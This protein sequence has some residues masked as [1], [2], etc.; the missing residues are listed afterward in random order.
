MPKNSPARSNRSSR[1]ARPSRKPRIA[2]LADKHQLY[3]R[4]VQC[5]EAEIDFVD[6]TFTKIRRRKARLLREDFCGTLNTSCEWARRRST[7]IAVGVDLDPAPLQWGR[8]NN[9]AKLTP[10]QR[11]RVHIH[12]GN[13][14]EPVP[15]PA[16]AQSRGRSGFDIVLAMNFSFWCFK[17]RDVLREYFRRVRTS[18][19]HDGVFFL[20]FYGGSDAL[21]EFAERRKIGRV[22]KGD[23]GHFDTV[24]RAPG[25][26]VPG[27]HGPYTYIWD[28]ARYNP[29]TGDQT[30]HIHFR[31]PDGSC[32]RNAFSYDWRLW[33]LPDVREIL[34]EA[35]F[36]KT[37]VYWEGDDGKGGGNGDFQP[38]EDG[39]AG[40]SYICYITAEP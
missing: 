9:L 26:E 33:M 40:I 22:K 1:A 11:A 27:Y 14:L 13:V 17:R 21:R 39:D 20:D 37:T 25:D 10:A 34:T 7:N 15:I 28:Q 4:A 38:S 3:Q 5:V 31:F 36:H 12:R 23:E 16:D 8:D 35:G 2:A 18:L 19:A 30:C 6:Q 24:V 32:L 29:I